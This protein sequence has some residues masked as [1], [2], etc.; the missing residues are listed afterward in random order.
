MIKV[1]YY[2]DLTSNNKFRIEKFTILKDTILPNMYTS[3]AFH[4]LT[5]LDGEIE[6]EDLEFIPELA[7]FT[8]PCP[9]GDKF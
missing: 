6:I 2:H 8:Y 5:V 9:C 1:S 7:L 3:P 4:I